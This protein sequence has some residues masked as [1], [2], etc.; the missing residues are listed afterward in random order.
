[1]KLT[2]YSDYSLRVLIY[3]GLRRDARATITDIADSYGISRHHIVKIVHKLGQLGY[4]ETV[5]GKNGGLYLARDPRTIVV[6]EVLRHTEPNLNLVECF[7]DPGACV[8]TSA[9]T[10]RSALDEA[11]TAFLDVLDDYTLADLLE[12][13]RPLSRRLFARLEP[14]GGD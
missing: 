4:V 8:L 1:M 2:L 7:D 9:C 6:G 3:L 11:L 13:R 10:L 5:R 12:P 14:A